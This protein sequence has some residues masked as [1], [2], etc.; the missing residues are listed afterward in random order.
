[1]VSFPPKKKLGSGV[2]RFFFCDFQRPG[3]EIVGHRR[4]GPGVWS[5]LWQ[6]RKIAFSNTRPG[7]PDGGVKPVHLVEMLGVFPR[8]W[9]W[10]CFFLMVFCT[11]LWGRV[12]SMWD[13]AKTVLAVKKRGAHFFLSWNGAHETEGYS[14]L[15]IF[16]RNDIMFRYTCMYIYIY[17]HDFK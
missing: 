5:T 9:L 7:W 16:K 17:T 3:F 1:M 15:Q 2:P 14:Y 12:S 6:V 10:F 13:M 4:V 8:L 11:M